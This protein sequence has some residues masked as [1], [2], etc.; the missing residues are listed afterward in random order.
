MVRKAKPPPR[1]VRPAD[2]QHQ[3]VGDG[4]DDRRLPGQT[5]QSEDD[6]GKDQGVPPCQ[7]E[8]KNRQRHQAIGHH[9]AEV[10]GER[11]LQ[12]RIEAV[13]QREPG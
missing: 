5:R 2:Q 11:K 4:E 12:T 7:V 6:C 9:L 8:E 3:T 10:S 1:F 13:Q